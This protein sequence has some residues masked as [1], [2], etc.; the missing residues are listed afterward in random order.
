MT[1]NGNNK[2]TAARIRDALVGLVSGLLIIGGP[3]VAAKVTS[4]L[5][6]IRRKQSEIAE[7]QD[8]LD[9]RLDRQEDRIQL[10]DGKINELLDALADFLRHRANP[11]DPGRN[12]GS[13]G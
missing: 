8:E 3:I 7:T 1:K 12:R 4:D 9:T 2:T 6:E 10:Q 11:T 13:R 5:G